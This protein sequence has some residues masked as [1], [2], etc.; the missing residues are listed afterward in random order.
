MSGNS[1]QTL[2]IREYRPTDAPCLHRIDQVC[3]ASDVAYSRSEMLFCLN[4]PGAIT[5]IAERTSEVVGFAVGRI[6]ADRFAHVLTL[7]VLPEARRQKVGTLL[8]N[9]LHDAFRNKDVV[10][11]VLEVST[12]NL[13]ARHLYEALQYQHL[14]TVRGYYNGREDAYRMVRF[15]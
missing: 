4:H 7:D 14:E 15:F 2:L 1:T 9:S 10:L 13:A 12:E 5:R 8:M 3:F 6:Q 11:A